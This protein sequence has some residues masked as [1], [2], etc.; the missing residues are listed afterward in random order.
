MHTN[1][2]IQAV[3]LLFHKPIASKKLGNSKNESVFRL[4]VT[5]QYI[6]RPTGFPS[7]WDV[8]FDIAS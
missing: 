1:T 2:Y 7:V 6:T 5:W 8:H 4:L 3:T